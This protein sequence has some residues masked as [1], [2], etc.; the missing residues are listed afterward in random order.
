M[1]DLCILYHHRGPAPDGSTLISL[2]FVCLARE[3]LRCP[4]C[5]ASLAIP[6]LRAQKDAAA[7]REGNIVPARSIKRGSIGLARSG[8]AAAGEHRDR[9]HRA[10]APIPA[11]RLL[12]PPLYVRPKVWICAAMLGL[13]CRSH[14]C[15]RCQV[16]VPVLH[17]ASVS[18]HGPW[19]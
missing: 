3:G 18:S 10:A 2:S 7:A 14:L 13:G 8:H 17:A 19:T 6:K 16:R 11:H 4:I 9:I 12:P 1:K 15:M 5:L